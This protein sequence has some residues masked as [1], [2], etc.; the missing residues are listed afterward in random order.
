[1]KSEMIARPAIAFAILAL[2]G[3]GGSSLSGV[4]PDAGMAGAGGTTGAGGVTGTGGTGG[5]AGATGTGGFAG[6]GGSATGGASSGVGGGASGSASGG[7]RGTDASS[8][9]GGAGQPKDASSD[10]ADANSCQIVQCFRAVNCVVRCGGA[11]V[12]SGC[13]PCVAPAFD[14]IECRDGSPSMQ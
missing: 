4:V 1:M 13:C 10:A 9:S 2:T 14:S 12:Q 3:C 11:V 8:G 7:G 5:A 6:T